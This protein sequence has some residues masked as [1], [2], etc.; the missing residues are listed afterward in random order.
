MGAYTGEKAYELDGRTF[1]QWLREMH[2]GRER[3]LAVSVVPVDRNASG[4]DVYTKIGYLAVRSSTYP[5]YVGLARV[6]IDDRKREDGTD[7]LWRP[8]HEVMGISAN[9]G[10]PCPR[11]VLNKLT[12]VENLASHGVDSSTI[13]WIAKF[14]TANEA[15]LAPIEAQKARVASVEPGDRVIFRG[16]WSLPSGN[17]REFVHVGGDTFRP[18]DG[19]GLF[20]LKGWKKTSFTV[21]KSSGIATPGKRPSALSALASATDAGR[22]NDGQ[23]QQVRKTTGPKL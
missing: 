15:V 16:M 14:R 2:G 10:A 6:L 11:S 5:G 1:A 19:E 8:E 18:A 13:G 17:A 9:R 21:E 7:L 20:N 4:S 23:H 22:R 12:P 3:V